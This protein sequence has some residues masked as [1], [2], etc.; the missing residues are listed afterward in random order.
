MDITYNRLLVIEHLKNRT[1]YNFCHVWTDTVTNKLCF[2][3]AVEN[4][5]QLYESDRHFF[6]LHRSHLFL[7]V[8]SISFP[9]Y[10]KTQC[11]CIC[12]HACVLKSERERDSWVATYVPRKQPNVLF[13]LPLSNTPSLIVTL[14]RNVLF[15]SLGFHFPG[16]FFPLFLLLFLGAVTASPMN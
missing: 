4:Y 10:L 3:R 16:V 14:M 8:Q 7:H 13:T 1:D 9:F 11:V 5:T 15:E 2:Q 12:V 6:R